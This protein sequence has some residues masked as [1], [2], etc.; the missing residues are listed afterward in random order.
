VKLVERGLALASVVLG[1][2]GCAGGT[3]LLHPAHVLPTGDVRVMAGLS[4]Q[5]AV[6]PL[7]D[8]LK[9][10]YD[11][12]AQDPTVP[13]QPGSNP[14][15]A[16]GALVAAA[17]APGIAPVIGA[18]VGVGAGFEGGAAYTGRG[19]RLDLRKAFG[20]RS[21]ALSI[22]AGFDAAF[23]GRQANAPLPGVDLNALRA[24][25][26]DV[27]VI[28]GWRSAAGLYQVWAG[29]RGGYDHVSIGPVSTEPVGA[30]QPL[31]NTMSADHGY[32]GGLAGIAIGLRHIHVALEL[33]ATYQLIS[34]TF[35]GN[36]AK[37]S[38]LV[39]TP[40]SAVLFDF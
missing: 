38:G 3:P 39:L 31:S 34:G 30:G 32:V 21:L 17:V 19:A 29:V 28:V 12:A 22:G 25:G 4:G 35:N 7:S 15:Y 14:Q 26:F 5:A 18:R 2:G 20:N 16:K 13:G 10:A 1:L 36:Q 9:A 27:P 23:L 24:F 40:G 6:G 11:Q 8:D 33:D 37:T